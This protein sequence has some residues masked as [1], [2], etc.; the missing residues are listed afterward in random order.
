MLKGWRREILCLLL[1]VVVVVVQWRLVR[2]RRRLK[3]L[4][5]ML[6]RKL[7]RMR[8]ERGRLVV[9]LLRFRLPCR[10]V[11]GRAGTRVVQ[12][13]VEVLRM[14]WI[15]VERCVVH[16]GAGRRRETVTH[17]HGGHGLRVCLVRRWRQ[18]LQ[19]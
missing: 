15:G 3:Q 11:E 14:M 5:G 13:V 7:A 9:V 2:R 4:L 8:V 18:R 19:Q 12:R 17:V 1:V 16:R 6:L 10:R